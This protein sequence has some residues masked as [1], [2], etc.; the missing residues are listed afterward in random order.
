MDK[1]ANRICYVLKSKV[2]K[3]TKCLTKYNAILFYIIQNKKS[4]NYLRVLQVKNYKVSICC[5]DNHQWMFYCKCIAP[6]RELLNM[7]R[8]RLSQIPVSKKK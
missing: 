7:S 5:A 3:V 6:I 2:T 8:I 1:L 4:K